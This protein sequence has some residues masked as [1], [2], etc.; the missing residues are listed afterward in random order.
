MTD[1]T[2]VTTQEAEDAALAAP[3]DDENPA[4]I[5]AHKTFVITMISAALFIGSV[6]IFIL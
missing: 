6:L 2:N 1:E 4:L 3:P 5:E